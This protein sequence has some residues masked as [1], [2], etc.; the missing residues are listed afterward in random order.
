[1]KSRV[2]NS[3]LGC[4]FFPAIC[5]VISIVNQPNRPEILFLQHFTSLCSFFCEGPQFKHYT[6]RINN[7]GVG[8]EDEMI[9]G[10]AIIKVTLQ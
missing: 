7:C 8:R 5:Y 3:F 9:W 2:K 4:G 1:V 6:L 10:S